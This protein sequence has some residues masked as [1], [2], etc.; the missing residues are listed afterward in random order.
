MD[1]GSG[2]VVGQLQA[3]P[4]HVSRMVHRSGLR[5]ESHE[6]VNAC[7]HFVTRGCYTEATRAGTIR[8]GRRHVLLKPAGLA[9]WNAFTHASDSLRVDFPVSALASANVELPARP[10]VL[11]DP[12]LEQT[13]STILQELEAGDDCTLLALQGLC[14]E[15]LAAVLRAPSRSARHSPPFVSRACDYLQEHFRETVDFTRLADQ[16]GVNR[17]HL[18]MSFRRHHA[19][20]MGMFVRRL[21]VAYVTEQ[22]RATSLPVVQIAAEAGFADQSHCHRVVKAQTG[23]TPGEWR[24]RRDN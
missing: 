18:A 5:L 4:F 1:H 12:R 21:R 19:C 11:S 13:C 7:L 16:L 8:V 23:R 15:L 14:M 10:V 2:Q 6:H 17:T 20:T 3:G 22:L 9:H 24:S